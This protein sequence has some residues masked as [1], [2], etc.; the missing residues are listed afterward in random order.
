MENLKGVIYN[1]ENGKEIGSATFQDTFSAV[2]FM[3]G[4]VLDRMGHG[5]SE[6]GGKGG[7][8]SR[9]PRDRESHDGFD[10]VFLRRRGVH[11]E[12]GI[13]AVDFLNLCMLSF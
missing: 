12:A 7:H 3:A 2:E 5:D 9:I 1:S 10:F 11:L 4:V 8:K 13:D 6:N